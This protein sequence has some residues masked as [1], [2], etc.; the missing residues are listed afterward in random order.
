MQ[1]L[2][3]DM[4]RNLAVEK[5]GGGMRARE[6][7]RG[8]SESMSEVGIKKKRVEVVNNRYLSIQYYLPYL[9][10]YLYIGTDD[11]IK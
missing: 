8:L 9:G 5:R 4:C 11:L 3:S 10:R 7:E 6:R 2:S 1:T